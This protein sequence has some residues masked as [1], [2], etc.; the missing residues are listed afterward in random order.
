M[1]DDLGKLVLR[2]TVGILT[3]LHGLAKVS[4]GVAGISGMLAGVGLPSSL[5]YGVY[6]GEILA[7]LIVII[8]FYSRIGALVIAANMLFA[9]W[10][11]HMKDVFALNQGG[12]WAIELQAFFLFT[13]LAVALIGPG[14]YAVNRR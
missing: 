7:P 11:A 5:A 9:I 13:A 10:L 4:A 12:G 2:L 1:A 14:R 6:V 8:G 3:L